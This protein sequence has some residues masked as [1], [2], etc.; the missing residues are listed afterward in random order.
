VREDH[1]L[2]NFTAIKHMARNLIRR[3]S[4]K[5]SLRLRRKAAAW[6]EE[7]LVSVIAA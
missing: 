4:S 5:G 2:A 3:A 1:A 7:F 6:S